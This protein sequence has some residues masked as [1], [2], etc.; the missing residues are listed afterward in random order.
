[1][2]EIKMSETYTDLPYTKFPEDQETLITYQ[3]VDSSSKNIV[4]TY[5]GYMSRGEFSEAQTY[6]NQHASVLNKIIINENTINTLL[7]SIIALERMFAND[8]TGYIN[9]V[10]NNLVPIEVVNSLP[11]TTESGKLYLVLES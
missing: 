8:I 2:E 3:N 1:M 11:A 5:L 10:T 7:Q 9:R 4:D 6:Y